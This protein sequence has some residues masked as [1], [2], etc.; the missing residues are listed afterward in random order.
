MEVH[1]SIRPEHAGT[2]RN[3]IDTFVN[4]PV[5]ERRIVIAVMKSV[6]EIFPNA[7][8]LICHYRFVKN[9]EKVAFSS[10]RDLRLSWHRRMRSF[11]G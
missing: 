5:F 4:G 10:Y 3:V 11:Q 7:I 1:L 2:N 6:S 8:Q 9:T